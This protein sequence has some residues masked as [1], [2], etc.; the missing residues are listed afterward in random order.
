MGV[1]YAQDEYEGQLTR[2][3]VRYDHPDP[4]WGHDPDIADHLARLRRGGYKVSA[5]LYYTTDPS[6]NQYDM[7]I[8]RQR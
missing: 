5:Q 3:H 8:A 2:I 1:V 4:D 7:V 6:I